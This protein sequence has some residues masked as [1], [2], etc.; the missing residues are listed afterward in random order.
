MRVRGGGRVWGPVPG[1]HDM[2][3]PLARLELSEIERLTEERRYFVLHAPAT[4]R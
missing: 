4:E 2:I 1:E 3:D